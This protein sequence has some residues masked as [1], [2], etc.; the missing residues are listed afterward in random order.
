[1]SAAERDEAVDYILLGLRLGRHV[2]GFV[3]AYYGPAELNEEVDAED[4]VEPAALVADA[5]ALLGRLEDGW[6]RDQ[7]GGLRTYAGV[8]AGDE[9]SY[10]DEVERCYGVRP[11]T[12]SEER[13]AAAHKELDRTLQNNSN[14]AAHYQS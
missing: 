13:F 9:L 6:L 3:D 8:L 11:E 1:M 14:L 2:E 5:D 12:V 7:V 4:L 10:S